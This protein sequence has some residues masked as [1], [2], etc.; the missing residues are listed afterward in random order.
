MRFL[1]GVEKEKQ[2]YQGASFREEMTPK[3]CA[4]FNLVPSLKLQSLASEV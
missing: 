1:E 4:Y 2:S 3:S